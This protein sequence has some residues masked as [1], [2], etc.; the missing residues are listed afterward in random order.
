MF[1]ARARTR[2]KPLYTRIHTSHVH[3]LYIHTRADFS[4]ERAADLQGWRTR[5]NIACRVSGYP[6]SLNYPPWRETCRERERETT[7]YERDTPEPLEISSS[8]ARK[9]GKGIGSA[10]ARSRVVKGA[11][12]AFYRSAAGVISHKSYSTRGRIDRSDRA[13]L[14]FRKVRTLLLLLSQWVCKFANI[15]VYTCCLAAVY[16]CTRRMGAFRSGRNNPGCASDL[17]GIIH[18]LRF[19]VR[20]FF[21]EENCVVAVCYSEISVYYRYLCERWHNNAV[22]RTWDCTFACELLLCKCEFYFEELHLT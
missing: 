5:G 21:N 19:S 15:R 6:W 1:R 18:E 12:V 3:V 14:A 20:R 9:L 22:C 13:A 2:D 17:I 10:R 8:H 4:C 11:R 7:P 16:I